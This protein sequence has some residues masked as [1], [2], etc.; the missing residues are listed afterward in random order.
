MMDAMIAGPRILLRRR[1]HDREPGAEG[2]VLE[3]L[4]RFGWRGELFVTLRGA[5]VLGR[6]GGEG[7]ADFV[8]ERGVEGGGGDSRGVW[9]WG[10]VGGDCSED[11]EA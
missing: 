6:D 8:L 10:R 1:R 9:G 5:Q 2:V 3:P 11:A 4:E 7:E